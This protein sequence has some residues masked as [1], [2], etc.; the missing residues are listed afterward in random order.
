MT[1]TF[2]RLFL[3]APL[4]GKIIALNTRVTVLRSTQNTLPFDVP[5]ITL[6]STI[7][8]ALQI[9][10]S[11]CPASAMNIRHQGR[12]VLSRSVSSFNSNDPGKP[13]SGNDSQNTRHRTFSRGCLPEGTKQLDLRRR[14]WPPPR[15]ACTTR[16]DLGKVGTRRIAAVAA[17]AC[18]VGHQSSSTSNAE[19]SGWTLSRGSHRPPSDEAPRRP[20]DESRGGSTPPSCEVL[21]SPRPRLVRHDCPRCRRRCRTVSHLSPAPA[22]PPAAAN[23][24]SATENSVVPRVRTRPVFGGMYK[25]DFCARVAGKLTR[26]NEG[27]R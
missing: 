11:L 18:S 14:D 26:G 24:R 10:P 12:T 16:P 1:R 23:W 2:A 25:N 4:E 9:S 27:G 5:R 13:G 3:R 8:S 22:Q 21:D 17:A 15:M 20:R 19:D 7:L 6:Y